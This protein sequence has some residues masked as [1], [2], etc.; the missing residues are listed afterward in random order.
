MKSNI[1]S[2]AKSLEKLFNAGYIDEKE[3]S[4]LKVEEVV[5]K[6]PDLNIQ[7]LHTIISFKH[8]LRRKKEDI[9]KFLVGIE[10]TEV[11]NK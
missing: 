9:L 5:L 1:M 7:D 2:I 11:K 4:V 8:A 10:E 6:V 3:I